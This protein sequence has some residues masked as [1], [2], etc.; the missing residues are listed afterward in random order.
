M[1]NN[2]QNMQNNMQKN[3]H[4]FVG[5]QPAALGAFTGPWGGGGTRPRPPAPGSL[6]TRHHMHLD[7]VMMFTLLQVI[8]I[9]N[10]CPHANKSYALSQVV[11]TVTSCLPMNTV[12]A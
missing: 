3:M 10:A 8:R 11:C 7:T 4:F 6:V 12:Y 2:V 5:A 1:H 9:T